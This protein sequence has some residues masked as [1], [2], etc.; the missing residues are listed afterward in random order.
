[1]KEE[2]NYTVYLHTSPSG[3]YYVG[4]TSIS[5]EQRWQNGRGYK[6]QVFYRAIQK[7][8]WDNIDHEIIA[9]NLTK[10][11][12]ENFEI[13]LI[14]ELHTTN[15]NYGYNVDNGGNSIGKMSEETKK[16]L[17]NKHKGFLHSEETKKKNKRK[18]YKCKRL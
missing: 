18:S 8:G 10:E 9:S 7:H 6:R 4:I 1:M 14:K 3:K 16:K 13:L 17:S 5:V 12:A 11:E 15:P 2:R